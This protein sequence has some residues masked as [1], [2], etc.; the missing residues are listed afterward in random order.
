MKRISYLLILFSAL[1][2][3]SAKGQ[4][5]FTNQVSNLTDPTHYSGV[6]LTV[7]DM[8]NDGLD[9]IV[10]L[11]NARD[12][13]IEYQNLNGVW[14]SVNGGQ[15]DA[16]N[17]WG[18]AAGDVTGNGQSDVLSGLFGGQP[19]YARA[20]ATGTSYTISELPVYGL[21]TQCVNL[22][23]MDADG[24]LDFFSCGDTGPSGIW[25]N[26]GS[27][28]FSYSGDD[29]IPMT[30]TGGWDG[31]GNYGSTFTDYDLDGDLDL[32]ITHCR[33]NV[34]SS[35]DLRRI[36][37][38]FINDGNGNYAEDFTNN[39]GLRI[40]AQSWTT[41]FQD[42]DN[43]GDFDAFITNHDVPNML[44]ENENNVFTDIFAGS[45][46]DMTVDF[47]LQGLM[48][49]FDNDMYVDII[50]TGGNHAYYKNNGDK[51]FTRI[52]NL[53]GTNEMESLA[54]GDLNHDGFLDIVGGYAGIY[55]SPSNT[56]D[57]L[58]INGGNDNNW[59]AVDLEG[60][61]SNGS[62]VGAIVRLYG[63]WGQQI[64]EVRSGESYGICNTLI[65]HFGLAQNTDIDSVVVDWPSSGI[66][67][68]VE[69]PQPN[70][71]LTIVENECVAPETFVSANGP[72]LIC[73]G[74]TLDLMATTGG[75]YDYEWSTGETAPQITVSTGGI[76]MVRV[77]D[78]ATGCSAVSASTLVEVSPDETPEITVT[79]ELSFCEGESVTLTSSEASAY[80]WSNGLGSDQSVQVTQEG[81]YSVTITGSCDDFTSI[82]VIVEVLPAPAPKANDVQ[83]PIPGTAD[84][85]ATG[86]GADFNWYDQAV[87]GSVMG[88]GTN[89]TTPVVNTTASFYVE[90][91][92]AFG[93]GTSYGAKTDNSV[94]QG[95]YQSASGWYLEFDVMANMRLKSVKVYAD[96][97]AD[98]TVYIE[99]SDGT[100]VYS[101]VF[102]I[103]DG[104]SRI[105]FNSWD[106]TPGTD[107]RFR[108]Q[109]SGH[110]LWRDNSA[111]GVNFPYDL[112]GLA[113]ITGANTSADTYYYYYYDWEVESEGVECV[114][115]RTEVV[116]TVSPVG[117][118]EGELS[119]VQI[120][121]NPVSDV[122]N[123][124]IP[125]TI[126]GTVEVRLMDVAGNLLIDS[127]SISKGT[128]RMDVSEL[129][130][131]IYL[132]QLNADNGTLVRRVSVQ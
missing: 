94:G 127:G 20:N 122:L 56:P 34:G 37:Q 79:G 57:A 74:Q 51:T 45:G 59:I 12:L 114:S 93:G 104:E 126:E 7:Q 35:T 116:V 121:P 77:T 13:K 58:W 54:V 49:D 61:I 46:L 125:T 107:Y 97:M 78:N 96:G 66:H 120:Y 15:M 89:F 6:A 41:D 33:Q 55:T 36:N 5:S 60:T 63:P 4:I 18:M 83:I 98:R 129:A 2:T 50:V 32:Y 100:P 102:S 42:M 21:A 99:T 101:Q 106:L 103:P 43:D 87:G 39:N 113:T 82:D 90:E 53:F 52:D 40:G 11:D 115:E 110:N 3:Y 75:N 17:A 38:M 119:A 76:Y 108:V 117:I 30:P 130:K 132:L 118:E 1:S 80:Q 48:R 84:L 9:D 111:S 29:I 27:G 19:D 81:T 10:I 31:S 73:N 14:T 44:M 112:S 22:A 105:N 24:D 92:H 91:V 64:R 124:Q 131:G 69:N 86:T 123:I 16:G 8:N 72:L 25:E 95:E 28:N 71:F 85:T 68:V 47:P 128:F 62:A 67:Q 70:Q 88:T 26:D 23:D 109:E 65:Q